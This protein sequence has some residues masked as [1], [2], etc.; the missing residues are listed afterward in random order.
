MEKGVE[1]YILNPDYSFKNDKDRIVMYSK[2][3]VQAYSTSDWVGYIH[4]LQADI[5]NT[6][7][8][9]IDFSSQCKTL[10]QKYAISCQQAKE[11]I[12]QFIC[13][14][15]L[16]Y[17]EFSG[18][19]IVF[20]KNVL[21]PVSYLN[22]RNVVR[23]KFNLDVDAKIDL[24]PDRMHS[25]PQSML[26]MLTNKCVTKCKYCYADKGTRCKEMSTEKILE[27][28][29]QA[30]KL[31]MSYVDVIGGE[32]FCR[33]DWDVILKALV[34]QDLTP[35]FISTKFPLSEEM[36][37]K[38]YDTKYSNV[39][40]VSLDS[41]S[42][43]VLENTIGC[44]SGYVEKMKKTIS[45]LEKYGFKIQINSILTK[46][47]AVKEELDRLYEYVED[48]SNLAYWEIRVPERSIYSPV[49]FEEVKAPR[50]QI[51][52]I[53]GYVKSSL[54]PNA[55]FKIM[56]SD[57]I[58]NE[59]LAEGISSDECF[60]GGTCGILQS[61]FFVLPDGKVSICEQMY[62]HPQ[63]II[64]DLSKQTIEE[65]WNSSKAKEIF[66]ME[67]E[68]FRKESKCRSCKI[69]DLCNKK[70]RRCAVKII[71]AYGKEN[72]DYPDPRCLYADKVKPQYCEENL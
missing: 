42:Q 59:H 58:L 29:E 61:A 28:I 22:N 48:I 67:R 49:T 55:H 44:K 16:V 40:Q 24:T 45:Y 15:T 38:L 69:F 64:G 25:A 60:H 54:I 50:K 27:I 13:N 37:K 43:T 18:N 41:L 8:D 17:T 36:V 71:R 34:D 4:P 20:P 7:S 14:D 10:A 39:V 23:R 26:L 32:V 66:H 65:V 1:V 57:E 46:D 63:Y 3:T 9:C 30:S 6:F 33:K 62:W 19:K 72:W 70:H 2:K 51:D 5:L 21:I 47:T 35:N 68:I 11:M 53:C 31:Q 56:C 52:A 12:E